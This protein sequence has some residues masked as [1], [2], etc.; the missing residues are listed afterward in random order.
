M[1]QTGNLEALYRDHAPALFRFLI[2]LTGSEAETKD[3][4]QELFVRLAKAGGMDD[5]IVSPRSWLF[6]LAHR[7]AIDRHRREE[8]RGRYE[9]RAGQEWA[10]SVPAVA[11]A[12]EGDAAWV[13]TTLRAALEALPAEQKA[14]VLLKIW[15]GLTF[16]EIAGV[17]DI[18]ANTAASRYRYA[19][20]K[21]Q[22][23]LRPLYRELL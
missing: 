20:D 13:Q 16:A 15:E 10:A 23:G 18:P 2:R 5:G 7:I 6:R 11:G 9:N 17:L 14:V 3:V 21:L 12:P 19:M 4:L 22:A 1:S 8:T